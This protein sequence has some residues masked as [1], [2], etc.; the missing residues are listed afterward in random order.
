MLKSISS[1]WDFREFLSL[2]EINLDRAQ[3]K[4]LSSK[5]F[6]SALHKLKKLDPALAS[7]LLFCLYSNTGR[8]AIDPAIL[9]RSFILM[10]HLGY[11]LTSYTF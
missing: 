6:R 7:D 1:I 3:R 4:R 9:I 11:I 2:E 5:L 10:Q 8:P